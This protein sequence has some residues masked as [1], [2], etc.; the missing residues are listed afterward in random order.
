MNTK[1]R[2]IACV[3]I[4]LVMGGM[5]L[6]MKT[7][8]KQ[9]GKHVPD[10]ISQ[11]SEQTPKKKEKKEEVQSEKNQKNDKKGIFIDNKIE[12]VQMGYFT[13]MKKGG[14]VE[15]ITYST[16][17]YTGKGEEYEKNALVYLPFGYDPEDRET[18]YDI[19][20]M[21]HGGGDDEKWYFG[22]GGY[23]S[24]LKCILDHMIANGDIPP[25][26][27]C[28][29]TYQNPYSANEAESV[30][31]FSQEFEKDLI[32]AV[33]GKYHT[34]Y[35]SVSAKNSRWHR[36]FSGF[37][38][39]AATTWW[40][41]EKCMD[42]VA[43][44][45]PI[46][47]DSWCGGSNG[48]KKVAHLTEAVKKQGY[49]ERDFLLFYG[50]GD[51]GEIAYHPVV[52]Q[53]KAM[54][55]GDSIFK[56]CENFKDGNFFYGKKES[57]GHDINTV[58]EVAYSGLQRMFSRQR[59]ADDYYKWAESIMLSVE[60][61]KSAKR[62]RQYYYGKLKKYQYYSR[63]AKR[64]TNVNVLLPPNYSR[65]ESYPVLYLLHGYYDNEDWM[66]GENMELK[67]I[68]GNLINHGKAKEMIVVMP[69]IFCSSELEE[70]TGM[71]LKNSL[72]YDNFVNDLTKDLMPFI[73]KKFSVAKGRENTA[74]TGFSMGGREAIFIGIT[75]SE[76]FGYVGG[77]CP[78]P[79]LTPGTDVSEHPGQLKEEE[80]VFPKGQEPY[81][82][83]LSAAKEDPA[84]GKMPWKL[85]QLLENNDVKHLWNVIPDGGHDAS[86]VRVHLYN[87]LRMIFRY[88]K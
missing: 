45:M 72:C 49:S 51:V 14:T 28:T 87:Y 82:F 9:R 23:D 62:D 52:S 84:V 36:G 31:Y 78:A 8:F 47:G 73:E 43:Y 33:E 75:H 64:Q 12:P 5:I 77:V 18:K 67:N 79:G 60:P 3:C 57:G 42:A 61:E 19:V 59:T 66:A 74:I 53:V 41:F 6:V 26:I 15:K 13:S 39:G 25:C 55:S 81:L 11:Q 16:R 48:E 44:F 21:M 83:L 20:Y 50:S 10:T 85:N 4:L 56:Y 37:S 58:C 70:C 68:L 22:E 2:I 71:D 86:S 32:P 30:K 40:V 80:L 24:D 46:S 29:P 35:D 76:L 1:K 17:D 63:T 65:D 38:M 7:Q 54:K 27:V 88:K 34:Y 69:Y